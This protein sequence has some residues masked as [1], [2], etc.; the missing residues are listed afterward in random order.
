MRLS[1]FTLA[2]RLPALLGVERR[3]AGRALRPITLHQRRIFILPT[4]YGMLYGAM[5]AVMTVTAA[6]YNNNLGF[7]LAFA[8]ASIGMTAI[9]HTYRNMA[10]L[11][12]RAGRA[13]PV[14]RGDTARFHIIAQNTSPQVRHSIYM[15][16]VVRRPCV[17]DIPAGGSATAA[18]EVPADRRGVLKPGIITIHSSYPIGLFRA[19]SYVQLD[20]HC[21]V[22]PNP[23]PGTAV[24]SRPGDGHGAAPGRAGGVDDFMGLRNYAAGDS[25]RHV[26]WKAL[27]RE[28]AIMTKQFA[29]DEDDTAW[30]DWW[31]LPGMA[32]EARLSVMCRWVLDA[33]AAGRR[34]GLRLPGRVLEAGSGEF[35]KHRC[36]QAL[37]L[38]GT[39]DD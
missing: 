7:I 29:R 14:F 31:A 28:Q 23:M 39:G 34:Y 27:A 25:L 13:P 15:Q 21:T 37:A 9:L 36:L 35:H 1:L 6:N 24:P 30:L 26:H 3:R 20:M 18:V 17:I 8:L 38:F 11:T 2:G 12:V 5:V 4:G 32:T 10:R 16:A 22:Y 33:A 19:W